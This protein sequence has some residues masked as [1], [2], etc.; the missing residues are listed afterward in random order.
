MRW[1]RG[2]W[3]ECWRGRLRPWDRGQRFGSFPVPWCSHRGRPR[4]LVWGVLYRAS[5]CNLHGLPRKLLQLARLASSRGQDGLAVGLQLGVPCRAVWCPFVVAFS[6]W[7]RLGTTA[8]QRR[9]TTCVRFSASLFFGSSYSFSM[10]LAP[11]LSRDCTGLCL[12]K[13][14]VAR[15]LSRLGPVRP[16]LPGLAVGCSEGV[17]ERPNYS[18]RALFF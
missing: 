17:L 5:C 11:G 2:G 6:S 3:W 9:P 1:F 13:L 14:C 12:R 4:L 18:V 16:C 15:R 7:R 10:S 8:Q